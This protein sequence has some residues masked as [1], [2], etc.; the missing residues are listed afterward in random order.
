M[1]ATMPDKARKTISATEMPA[2]FGVSP[3]ITRWMLLRRFIHGDDIAGPEH[4]RMDWGLR[5][6]PLLLAQAAADLRVGVQVIANAEDNYMRRGLLGCTR[7]ADVFC[8]DRG[9]GTLECKCVFDYGVWMEAW[10]G[11]KA[12]PRHVEIQTQ[13]QMIVGDGENP[14]KWGVIAVWVC[15]DMKYFER[16]PIGD[17][18]VEINNEAVRFFADVDAGNTGDPFGEPV[19]KPLLDKLFPPKV[20]LTLDLTTRPDAEELTNQVKL[21]KHHGEVATANEKEARRLKAQLLALMA[22][23]ETAKL[24]GGVEVRASTVRK[25]AY[26]VAASSYTQVSAFVP[27]EQ[28]PLAPTTGGK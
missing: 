7:D 2:L 25:K 21:M 6:Q 23:A 13:Q 9:P 8:P 12:P 20:G 3:Y 19:E 1:A 24:L 17:L 11:G 27:S 18:W 4:N 10:G 28:V 26:S 14:F 15:G 22:G 5:M 16:Q